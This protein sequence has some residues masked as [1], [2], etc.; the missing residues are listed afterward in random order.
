MRLFV[1]IIGLIIVG[2]SSNNIVPIGQNEY[3]LEKSVAGQ[4][5][6]GAEISAKL[7]AEAN[8]FCTKT[9]K[10]FMLISVTEKD[11]QS[12]ESPASSKLQ[13][14]CVVYKE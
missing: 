6:T 11:Y 9:N 3:M 8:M 2:C 12:P 5:V 7:H 1:I 13:F 14:H 4:N 10:K